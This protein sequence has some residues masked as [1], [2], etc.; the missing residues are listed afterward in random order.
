MKRRAI[1]S[2][3]VTVI[4]LQLSSNFASAQSPL[5]PIPQD[6]EVRIGVL[7]N[8]LTYYIRA[9]DKP[10]GQ[11]DFYIYSDVGA[12]QEADDQQGLAHFMEHMAFNGTKNLPGKQL[13]DYL[14]S[15]G[16]K[17]GQNLNAYTALDETVYMMKDVPVTRE[18]VIDTALLILH[19]WAYYIDPKPEEIDKERGVIKE[20]LR[21]RDT[22]GWRS[23]MEQ[24]KSIGMGTI[25]AERNIIGYLDFLES[26]PYEALTR[27]YHDWYRPDYQAL[28]IV[29]DIDVDDIEQR[30]IALC[31]DIPAAAATAPQK[32]TVIVPDNH[33]P[34]ISIYSD[35]EMTVS[36]ITII[37][38]GSATPIEERNTYKQAWADI[39]DSYITKIMSYRF[40]DLMQQEGTPLQYI[41]FDR[42]EYIIPTL[43]AE[44]TWTKVKEGRMADAFNMT[45]TEMERM[46][47][48]GF[49][50]DEWQRAKV[51][52]LSSAKS[53]YDGRYD[54]KNNSYISRY[55]AAY[56]E[57]A[58]IPDALTRYQ[59][60]TTYINSI[61]LDEINEVV[62][63]F[64]FEENMV[65]LI[66][67]IQ[68]DGVEIPT[69]EQVLTWM[70][71]IQA[72]DITPLEEREELPPLIPEGTILGG[73]PVV[74]ERTV[75]EVDAVEWTLDNGIVVVVKP[76]T[77]KQN[78]VRIT[79]S[80]QGG[81]SIFTGR[82]EAA[83]AR[84]YFNALIS[85]M[86]LGEFSATNLRR[87]TTGKNAWASRSVGSET[88]SVSGGS[89][90]EDLETMLQLI[91]L[92]FTSPRYDETDY[93][94]MMETM[95][96]N[97]ANQLLSP[98]IQAYSEYQ[99]VLYGG[100]PTKQI[101]NLENLAQVSFSHL[102]TIND[103]LFSDANDFRFTIIGNVDLDTL[104]PLVEQYIGSLPTAG[105]KLEW[106]DDGVRKVRGE[107]SHDFSTR[108]EQPKVKVMYHIYS[109][110]PFTLRKS[111]VKTFLKDALDDIYLNRIREEKGGTYGVGVSVG[112]ERR[113]EEQ[114]TLSINFD[115]NVEMADELM[116]DVLAG[117]EEIINQGVSPEQMNKTREFLLKDF[118][119]KREDNNNW[120]YLIRELYDHNL[121]RLGESV[122]I[123]NGITSEEV[124][125]LAAQ[126]YQSGNIVK[127][128]MRPE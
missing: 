80:A 12:I 56:S 14:E 119:N 128:V 21:T 108:M 66:N 57:N 15:I 61:S 63:G 5:D 43:S 36:D 20:E 104:K 91:Y 22:A 44:Y 1:F 100:E 64:N 68:K 67:S 24:M 41:Y 74:A 59:I 49:N 90:P 2:L 8:G 40:A 83:T 42:G 54:L 45:Y 11:A 37:A 112:N 127:V 73:S 35:P 77:F 25:Y 9:N 26:F 114:F 47:R 87:A 113:P 53:R 125:A 58:A 95:R 81:S 17:F 32:Q 79:S 109:Q 13:I 124:S 62:K 93:N 120:I 51:D 111:I 30:I 7:N 103:A 105:E 70:E 121:D 102:E 50:P 85:S 116:E 117:V 18:G 89:T 88:S 46:R 92:Q 16:V 60:D 52:M 126:I 107:V 38:K 65:I 123:I 118:E 69:Q 71:S 84:R 101:N 98:N 23:F 19:D 97:I 75:E 48:H 6:E 78:E 72:S 122:D 3:L 4:F 29:G 106:L 39:L 110:E 96:N 31:G 99:D 33:E 82:D 28:I 76:T 94:N 86:G 34:I 55:M 115:T 10:K 27:F